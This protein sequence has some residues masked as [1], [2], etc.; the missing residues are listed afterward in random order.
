[1][2]PSE[3]MRVEG[4]HSKKNYALKNARCRAVKEP[5][6]VT[7]SQRRQERERERAHFKYV[8]MKASS[9]TTTAGSTP[10]AVMGCPTDIE[11]LL[12]GSRMQ[13]GLIGSKQKCNCSSIQNKQMLRTTHAS[14]HEAAA[15]PLRNTYVHTQ[16]NLRILNHAY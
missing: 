14:W 9:T 13:W 5:I 12:V 7:S 3:C 16:T 4:G 2:T 6:G 1:M 10:H 8:C 11:R 15:R